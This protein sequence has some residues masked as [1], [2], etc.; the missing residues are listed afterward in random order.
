M[1]K[2]NIGDT[3]RVI[4]NCNNHDYEIGGEYTIMCHDSYFI[5]P[6]ENG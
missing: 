1:R 3:I 2:F 4:G 6:N 5:K